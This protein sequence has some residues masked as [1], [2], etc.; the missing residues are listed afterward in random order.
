MFKTSD[1]SQAGAVYFLGDGA[2]TGQTDYV[3]M[4]GGVL[5][6]VHPDAGLRAFD[7]S[8][9]QFEL[10]PVLQTL[11]AQEI[12]RVLELKG[13]DMYVPSLLIETT[14][15]IAYEFWVPDPK[16][17]RRATLSLGAKPKLETKRFVVARDRDFYI[18]DT[19]FSIELE[20]P[21]QD[22]DGQPLF[23]DLYTKLKVD[24]TLVTDSGPFDIV[25]NVSTLAEQGTEERV[26]F[27]NGNGLAV[28]DVETGKVF[29][30]VFSDAS[31]VVPESKVSE[32]AQVGTHL[33]VTTESGRLL[34]A[35]VSDIFS[36]DKGVALKSPDPSDQSLKVLQGETEKVVRVH[37]IG[38]GR[39]SV[40]VDTETGLF[41]HEFEISADGGISL[42]KQIR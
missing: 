4:E 1:S 31:G 23:M 38:E 33:I 42:K 19:G 40:V 8:G 30:K 16:E 2:N 15:R 24:D 35:K 7:L 27:A 28:L 34:S 14:S 37:A 36:G 21:M 18:T 26:V 13:E 25:P 11:S 5:L 10:P 12:D 6:L 20:A 3:T 9:A 32:L 39:F 29:P 17:T 22:D 41:T